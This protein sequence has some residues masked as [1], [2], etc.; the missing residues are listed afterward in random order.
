MLDPSLLNQAEQ[1]FGALLALPSSRRRDA[2]D[3][4][5]SDNREL[6]EFVRRLLEHDDSGMG[7]FLESP[8]ALPLT[9]NTQLG[10][11]RLLRRLGEGG[12]GIVYEARQ[13]SPDRTVALKVIRGGRFVDRYS[14]KLFQR[15]VQAL[16]R[17]RHPCIGAIYEAGQTD[18][19][20][21]YFAMELVEGRPLMDYVREADQPVRERLALFRR[22]CDAIQY[23]HQRGVMHRDL[24]PSNILIDA[25]G[26]PR[27]LD[28]GLARITDAEL[29]FD[30]TRTAAGRIQGTLAYMSPE[31]ARGDSAEIDIRSDVYSLGVILYE[32]L[33]DRLP[34]D[35]GGMPLPR[36]VEAI[37]AQAPRKSEGLKGD[38]ETIALKA[39]EKEP[40]RRYASAASLAEDIQRFL[41][42]QPI[43]ARRDSAWYVLR[44]ALRRHRVAASVTAAFV[45][46]VSASAV[47]LAI[48]YRGQSLAREAEAAER[49]RAESEASRAIEERDKTEK[50]AGFMEEILRGAGPAVAQGKDTKLIREMMESAA[51][52]IEG[53]ELKSTPSA[54]LRLREVIGGVC[55]FLADYDAARRMIEPMRD[56][57]KQAFGDS[58]AEYARALENLAAVMQPQGRI[59]EALPVAQ[60]ALDVTI[61]L[62]AG[63]HPRI[64]SCHDRLGMLLRDLARYAEAVPHLEAS[65]EMRRRLLGEDNVHVAQTLDNLSQ[66]LV[67][68]GRPAD[69]LTRSEEALG[70][71]RRIFQGDQPNLALTLNTIGAILYSQGKIEE[72]LARFEEAL[73][74]N[75]RLF[76]GD[77][78]YVG[79]GLS[80][81]GRVL[82]DLG[83]ITDALPKFEESVAIH[84]RLYP[85]DHPYLA[86]SLSQMAVG[87][88][89]ADRYGYAL[90]LHEEALAMRKRLFSGEHPD[91]ARSLSAIGTVLYFQDQ[92]EAALAKHEEALAMMRRLFPNDQAEVAM[93]LGY[94]A[95]DLQAI[96]R[97]DEALPRHEEAVAMLR[98]LFPNDNRNVARALN[99]L[100]FGLQVAGRLDEA[101][102]R[103]AEAMAM[104][105]RIH[106]A[107]EDSTRRTHADLRGV[108]VRR[109]SILVDLRRY[110][111]AE[112][113]L[114][115]TWK[116][117]AERTDVRLKVK[118]HC[119]EA[120]IQ[121]YQLL[122]DAEPDRDHEARA[123][124]YRRQLKELLSGVGGE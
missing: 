86:N 28:F 67:A 83:R 122:D 65:L 51:K 46:L 37:C 82:L 60:K 62:H 91:I 71:Y 109:G 75:R 105:E 56:L 76:P 118:A 100:A 55:I 4:L 73:A 96:G 52:R 78:P 84:R 106:P 42:D 64:A 89:Y 17:L 98:R 7:G 119:L 57:A 121:L 40:P 18:D 115:P 101:L 16:A 6:A 108:Q 19:Q 9:E 10:R 53:G 15:E 32:L 68:A 90:P 45:L 92:Y 124:E 104:T 70:I 103:C 24:K 58:S 97:A 36:A 61:R 29:S 80:N 95:G 39:M 31:Q 72:A 123:G 87:F 5:Q 48:M 99:N 93:N 38:L 116:D 88:T 81:I 34:Y 26:S 27:I 14:V 12:M 47:A 107:I 111:E 49:F 35:V 22:I 85:G 13:A 59:A 50:F 11:F 102:Q 8:R 30:A 117:I 120:L 69:A 79:T 54:E 3:R 113:I 20:Q 1:L 33:T 112:A 94:V 44:K 77:H 21:H 43:E 25:D 110:D 74:M 66:T 114:V 63:D 2:L 23:A 41:S